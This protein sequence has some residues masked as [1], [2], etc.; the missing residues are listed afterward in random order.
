MNTTIAWQPARTRYPQNVKSYLAD[1]PHCVDSHP[2][3]GGAVTGYIT[4]CVRSDWEDLRAFIPKDAKSVLDIGGGIGGLSLFLYHAL[5]RPSLTLVEKAQ[6]HQ[7]TRSHNVAAA[8][9]EFLTLNGVPQDKVVVLDSDAP[10]A[11]RRLA[12][13]RHDVIVSLRA[14]G[15][16]FSYATY[17]QVVLS[18]LNPGGTLIFDLP[19]QA[20]GGL[21]GA[22]AVMKLVGREVGPPRIVAKTADYL[23]LAA[24]RIR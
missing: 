16:R 17:R 2:H 5:K 21:R 3:A 7:G 14:L 9:L 8:A 23:R 6:R 13:G 12:L 20:G 10:D 1:N 4:R 24:R 19:L 18:A 22:D 11:R 15:Y